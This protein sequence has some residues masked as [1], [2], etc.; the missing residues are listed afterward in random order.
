MKVWVLGIEGC[1][2]GY[3]IHFDLFANGKIWQNK[4]DN[5]LVLDIVNKTVETERGKLDIIDN[6][7]EFMSLVK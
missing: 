1:H 7:R 3:K 2:L 6:Y 4:T 5:I